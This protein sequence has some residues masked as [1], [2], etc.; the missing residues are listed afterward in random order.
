VKG[1]VSTVRTFMYASI[2][3]QK[4]VECESH[5]TLPDAYNVDQF[6]PD[7]GVP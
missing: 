6:D 1:W 5:K 7:G 4:R 3:A 2:Q